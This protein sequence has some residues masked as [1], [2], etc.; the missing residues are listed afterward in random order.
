MEEEEEVKVEGIFS[1]KRSRGMKISVF[2]P[3]KKP[4]LEERVQVYVYGIELDS[5]VTIISVSIKLKRN[6]EGLNS[7]WWSFSSYYCLT[8]WKC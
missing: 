4:L 8:Q 5:V 1:L 2:M 6:L 7:V 3:A